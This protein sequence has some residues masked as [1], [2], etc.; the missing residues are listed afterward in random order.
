MATWRL[1]SCASTGGETC[2]RLSCNWLTNIRVSTSNKTLYTCLYQSDEGI[3]DTQ[4]NKNKNNID[5]FNQNREYG[6]PP[7]NPF[8][9]LY[10]NV[11]IVHPPRWWPT[12]INIF[13]SHFHLHS[14]PLTLQSLFTSSLNQDEE[15]VEEKIVLKRISISRSI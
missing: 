1:R 13:S 10:N 5:L 6:D 15:E 12:S 3:S 7:S 8:H 4:N 2:R 11:S 14:S 9:K